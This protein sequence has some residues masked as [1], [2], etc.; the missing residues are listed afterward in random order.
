M[1]IRQLQSA[2]ARPADVCD[3]DRG[4]LQVA[5]PSCQRLQQPRLT[6]G[7]AELRD[8]DGVEAEAVLDA[9]RI[10]N[11]RPRKPALVLPGLPRV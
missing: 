3:P 4:R 8:L 5:T 1:P 11:C 9:S 6:V 10:Q 2:C 7:R